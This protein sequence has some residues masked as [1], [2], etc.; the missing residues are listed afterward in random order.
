MVMKVH[1]YLKG[2]PPGNKNPEKPKLLEYFIE[3]VNRSG[4]Q[5]VIVRNYE[6]YPSDVALLQGFVHPESKHVPHLNLRRA[7]L[8][9]QARAG[10]RTIIADA[11]LFLYADPG[12]TKTYLRYSYD[13][14]F[15]TTAE[16]CWNPVNPRRW[17]QISK[18]LNLKLKPYQKNGSTVLICCQRDGGWS[19]KGMGVMAWLHPLVMRIRRNTDREIVIRFHPGD[20]K[21]KEHIKKVK[22]IGYK[23]VTV[24]DPDTNLL[25]EL[26]R[27]HCMVNHNSSPAVAAAIEGVPVFV[28]DP[29]NSQAG[30][31]AQT[32]VRE[33]EAIRQFDRE[34]WIQKVAMSHWRLDELKSGACWKH[35]RQWAKK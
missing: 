5:G 2:I 26:R 6:H 23:N 33:I 20:K 25:T 17:E 10:K 16:Y 15:P 14:I 30:D 31:I 22:S 8:E 35:M 9:N 21:I 28:L 3:G 12:N 7:V 18:D 24:S 13:G 4:D 34:A 1:A 29:K 11:N 27:A 32:D 19:M